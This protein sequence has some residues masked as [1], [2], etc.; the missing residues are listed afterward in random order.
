[1]GNYSESQ[2][3]WKRA[4]EALPKSDLKPAEQT[5]KAQYQAGLDAA[6]AGVNK[7]KN[8]PTVGEQAIIV[9][10]EGRMPWDLAAA[11]IPGLRAQRPVNLA[12]SVGLWYG[13]FDP[14][15]NNFPRLGSS[16]AHMRSVI[17]LIYSQ[18]P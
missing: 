5:Q 16:M 3:S 13:I 10:G 7:M 1:M 6:I 15:L 4:L 9:Q 17:C 18:R 8:T 2:E 14:A 12:S 11:M